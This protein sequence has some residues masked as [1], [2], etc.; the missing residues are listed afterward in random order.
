MSLLSLN[1]DF[2]D[3]NGVTMNVRCRV[4][5]HEMYDHASEYER[6]YGTPPPVAPSKHSSGHH[7][8]YEAGSYEHDYRREY[9]PQ[10]SYAAAAA[11]AYAGK[12]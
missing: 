11:A 3:D 12:L 10:S 2:R 7:T 8:S 4:R 1:G 6:G 9:H 5:E